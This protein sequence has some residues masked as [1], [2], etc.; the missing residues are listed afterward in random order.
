V[1]WMDD[2]LGAPLEH[3]NGW[4]VWYRTSTNGG[5]SWNGRSVRVSQFDRNR[6]ESHANGFEFPYGDYQGIDLLGGR[7]VMVW[8]EG[9]NYT[10]GASNPG[11]VIYRSMAT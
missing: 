1:I 8:G 10:G 7:A 5:V 9:H 11:H 3:N 6:S 2:R 4:N